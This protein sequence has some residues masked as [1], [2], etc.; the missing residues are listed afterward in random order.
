MPSINDSQK[1]NLDILELVGTSASG[2]E[3]VVELNS[4]TAILNKAANIFINSAIAKIN[5]SK[6]V[7]TGNLQDIQIIKS[8]FDGQIASIEIGY[9][10][11]M[12]KKMSYWKYQDKGVKGLDSNKPNSKYFFKKYTVGGEFLKSL[13][14]WYTLNKKFIKNEDQKSGLTNIQKKRK[15]LG[16]ITSKRIKSIAYVT[17]KKI[18]RDGIQPILFASYAYKKA[19]NDKFY[20]DLSKA[21]GTDI[22]VSIQSL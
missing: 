20:N 19:F 3:S 17:G 8:E 22:K 16:S 18:K 4:F 10:P 6:R 11:A 2:Y 14:A 9:T 1:N 7:N 21:I 12:A 5:K 13:V 15:T